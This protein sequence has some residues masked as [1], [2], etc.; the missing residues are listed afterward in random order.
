MDG[1]GR[2]RY[3]PSTFRARR[4]TEFCQRTISTIGLSGTSGLLSRGTVVSFVILGVLA[5]PA[6]IIF[7]PV[8]S[9][10]SAFADGDVFLQYYPLYQVLR[11]ALLAGRSWLWVPG[12]MTGFPLAA[13]VVGGM[14]SPVNLVLFR[15]FDVLTAYHV[16]TVANVI[17]AGAA[18]YW[19]SRRLGLGRAASLIAGTV[20]PWSVAYVSF[21]S[22]ITVSNGYWLLPVLLAATLA[23]HEAGSRGRFWLA[24]G[25]SAVAVALGFFG[26]H[27]Q[28]VAQG[29]AVGFAWALWL[30]WRRSSP[31]T[32]LWYL[33]AV[34]LGVALALPQMFLSIRYLPLSSREGGLSLTEAFNGGFTFLD[35]VA[36]LLPGLN[37][38]YLMANP[39]FAYVGAVPLLL[40]LFSFAAPISPHLRFFRWL[41]A[42]TFLASFQYSPVFLALHV[43]PGLSFFRG[44]SRWMYVANVAVAVLAAHGFAYLASAE[45]RERLRR[46]IRLVMRGVVVLG[47]VLLLWNLASLAF[48]LKERAYGVLSRYFDTAIYPRTTKLPLE[49]YHNVIRRAVEDIWQGTTFPHFTFTVSFTA[50]IAAAL[51]LAWWVRRDRSPRWFGIL[52]VSLTLVNIVPLAAAKLSFVPASVIREAPGMMRLIRADAAPGP[53]RVWTFF[54]GMTVFT[55]L[56]T[57]FGY[58]PAENVRFQRELIAPNVGLAYGVDALDNYDNFM[59]RRSSRVLGYLGSDRA[60][61]GESLVREKIPFEEK[62]AKFVERL[63]LLS[64]FNVRYVVSAFSLEHP[65]LREIGHMRVTRHRVELLLYENTAVWPRYYLSGRVQAVPSA[66]EQTEWAQFLHDSAA[67]PDADFITCERCPLVGEGSRES[68]PVVSSDGGSSYTFVVD[69]GEPRWF[70]FGQNFLPGWRATIDGQPVPIH[71][72]NF[73]NQAV[74]V[75]A[76]RHEVTFSFDPFRS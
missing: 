62:R 65:D 38:P 20:L 24:F 68:I 53:F 61:Y 14:L 64:R 22:N 28:W 42:V 46:P 55:K 34:A 67:D 71:R 43:I 41:Y 21:A 19:L 58:E 75:P 4:F 27:P 50:L 74:A 54:P 9:G 47:A 59:D 17:A 45:G 1:D 56:D 29:I 40:L 49:H 3:E 51:L 60:T 35:P 70:V 18:T 39:G 12:V 63:P 37:I 76:G 57:P 36:Y 52:A 33:G 44:P 8:L 69:A 23:M 31:R 5:V 25:V 72:A 6:L 66:G 30:S 16:V 15:F 7:W 48:S 2:M 10:R 13:S 73:L 32:V 26:A 11:G